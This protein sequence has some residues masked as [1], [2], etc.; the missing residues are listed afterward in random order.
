MIIWYLWSASFI[1][2]YENSV[3]ITELFFEILGNGKK[4]KVTKF[5]N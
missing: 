5:Q 4:S 3:I 2:E 1:C